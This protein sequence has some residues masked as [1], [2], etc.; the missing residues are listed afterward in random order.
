MIC[1]YLVVNPRVNRR[2]VGVSHV[3]DGIGGILPHHAGPRQ[4][5]REWR[6]VLQLLGRAFPPFHSFFSVI[7]SHDISL[8]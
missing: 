8:S 6:F 5:P 1:C 3:L 4:R 2:R 7:A